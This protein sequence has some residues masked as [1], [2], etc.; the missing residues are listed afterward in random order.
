[1]FRSLMV[2]G[3]LLTAIPAMSFAAEPGRC[4]LRTLRGCDK[5]QLY[6]FDKGTFI[7]GSVRVPQ[8]RLYTTRT[9]V[10]HERML[11]LKKDLMPAIAKTRGDRA[12]R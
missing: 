4:D 11:R 6:R 1:M 3:A 5:S 10:R 7:E 12:L 2:A 8:L 9:D